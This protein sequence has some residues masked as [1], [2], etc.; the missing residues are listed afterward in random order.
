M[1]KNKICT[2]QVSLFVAFVFLF[3]QIY[4]PA[5]SDT[6]QDC[7][8]VSS[9]FNLLRAQVEGVCSGIEEPGIPPDRHEEY[10]FPFIVQCIGNILITEKEEKENL[11]VEKIQNYLNEMLLSR[12]SANELSRYDL[13]KVSR[14]CNVIKIELKDGS[15]FYRFYLKGDAVGPE[16]G[17]IENTR[18]MEISG[19][20][21]RVPVTAVAQKISYTGPR[22]I[23]SGNWTSGQHDKLNEMIKELIGTEKDVTARYARGIARVKSDIAESI[24]NFFTN[25]DPRYLGKIEETIKRTNIK[26]DTASIVT[27]LKE[28]LTDPKFKCYF[29]LPKSGDDEFRFVYRGENRKPLI[30]HAQAHFGHNKTRGPG[31]EQNIYISSAYYDGLSESDRIALIIHEMVHLIFGDGNDAHILGDLIAGGVSLSYDKSKYDLAA[32]KRDVSEYIRLKDELISHVLADDREQAEKARNEWIGINEDIGKRGVSKRTLTAFILEDIA[33]KL[34]PAF[35]ELAELISGA[36]SGDMDEIFEKNNIGPALRMIISES[37]KTIPRY[38]ARGD[39]MYLTE[40]ISATAEKMAIEIFCGANEAFPPFMDK[41]IDDVADEVAGALYTDGAAKDTWVKNMKRDISLFNI[42]NYITPDLFSAGSFANKKKKDYLTGTLLQLNEIFNKGAAFY[43]PEIK[44][45]FVRNSWNICRLRGILTHELVHYLADMGQL[46]ADPGCEYTTY[47]IGLCADIMHTGAGGVKE[48]EDNLDIAGEGYLPGA[49]L[50]YEKGKEISASGRSAYILKPSRDAK[51][52]EYFSIDLL[53]VEAL[54]VYEANGISGDQLRRYLASRNKKLTTPFETEQFHWDRYFAQEACGFIM[55][56]ILMSEYEKAG[57]HPLTQLRDYFEELDKVMGPPNEQDEIWIEKDLIPEMETLGRQLFGKKVTLESSSTT[58]RLGFWWCESDRF[59]ANIKYWPFTIIPKDKD[60]K[61]RAKPRKEA[62]ERA[63]GN[64]L[65]ALYRAHNTNDPEFGE[66]HKE[67]F[68]RPEF[69]VLW[70]TLLIPRAVYV[71]LPLTQRKTD[72]AGA[73]MYKDVPDIIQKVFDARYNFGNLEIEKALFNAYPLHMRYLDSILYRWSQYDRKKHADTLPDDPRLEK[74]GV[75][76]EAARKSFD[77]WM[78]LMFF[79]QEHTEY[80]DIYNVMMAQIWPVYKELFEKDLEI[81]KNR[82]LYEMLKDKEGLKD[83]FEDFDPSNLTAEQEELLEDIFKDLPQE[84]KDMLAENSEDMMNGS[85]LGGQ[86][87]QAGGADSSGEPGPGGKGQSGQSS[88]GGSGRKGDSQGDNKGSAAGKASGSSPA[89]A[90]EEGEGTQGTAALAGKAGKMKRADISGD[91]NEI[92]K[93]LNS[94][95]ETIKGIGRS[96]DNIGKGAGEIKE[97]TR[98]GRKRSGQIEN[99]K[100]DEMSEKGKVL[101]DSA[102]ELRKKGEGLS[103]KTGEIRKDSFEAGEEMPLSG[104]D[105]GVKKGAVS[106]E[107]DAKGINEDIKKLQE[108]V[109]KLKKEIDRLKK[110]NDTTRDPAQISELVD[111]IKDTAS[112]A[113]K[114]VRDVGKGVKGAAGTVEE[115]RK[116]VSKLARAVEE[117]NKEIDKGLGDKLDKLGKEVGSGGEKDKDE[118]SG[119]L[120][121]SGTQPRDTGGGAEKGSSPRKGTDKSDNNAKRREKG[122]EPTQ[123][124]PEDLKELTLPKGSEASSLRDIVDSTKSREEYEGVDKYS[125]RTFEAEVNPE[126]A[127][128]LEEEMLLEE[129]RRM[130]LSKE[131]RE[132]YISW[133]S[134]LESNML[135][136]MRKMIRAFTVPAEDTE[137]ESKKWS[138]ILKKPMRALTGGDPYVVRKETRPRPAQFVFLI[139]ISGSMSG[140][141]NLYARLTV[142]AFLLVILEINKELKSRSLP[143]IEFQVGRFNETAKPLIDENVFEE[144]GEDR[145]PRLIYDVLKA[146][147]ANG[148]TD[149]INALGGFITRLK[150]KPK[151]VGAENEPRKVLFHIGDGDVNYGEKE[152]MRKVIA[153]AEEDAARKVDV[154][155]VSTGDDEARDHV[156]QAFG[157]NRSILPVEPDLS[158]LPE[159]CLRRFAESLAP[160]NYDFPWQSVLAR[161]LML[162]TAPASLAHMAGH[163]LSNIYLSAV[164]K[165]GAVRERETGYRHFRYETVNGKDYLVWRRAD[166]KGKTHELRWQRGAGGKNVPA[167][168]TVDDNYNEEMMLKIIRSMYLEGVEYTSYSEDGKYYLRQQ[169]KNRLVLMEKVKM[170]DGGTEWVEKKEFTI[171]RNAPANTEEGGYKKFSEE[172]VNW[173]FDGM[174]NLYIDTGEG[175][176]AGVICGKSFSEYSRVEYDAE[177]NGYRVFDGENARV[178]FVRKN[179]KDVFDIVYDLSIEKFAKAEDW[180]GKIVRLIGETGLG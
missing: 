113:A 42:R 77:G 136:D 82:K 52:R 4:Y 123:D 128:M 70:E 140:M 102:D 124:T 97:A 29:L 145:I 74:G 172:G 142:M 78:K 50:L 160:P 103:K 16:E 32:V 129:C 154:F 67:M 146:L 168:I 108:K 126:W 149:Q 73:K 104:M 120:E 132:E 34:G 53:V 72:D 79:I 153:F 14:A 112:A 13:G 116:D 44:K 155:G 141:R 26:T 98:E 54:K 3:N 177:N 119:A 58:D 9:Q 45:I 96:A 92:E 110:F 60:Q 107:E 150:E 5:F 163:L 17:R 6:K 85:S 7:L 131:E 63:I 87:G 89:D 24:D 75:V 1:K 20:A 48:R 122:Q 88:S 76:D 180:D 56:G 39:E 143:L 66:G 41:L 133:L 38:A 174:S 93:M 100:L 114:A 28:L 101:K 18:E 134:G 8:G 159:L 152:S 178:V 157:E 64:L 127:K 139:D 61:D 33:E 84:V 57:V 22:N 164:T 27:S 23:A 10:V 137:P 83:L 68:A 130:G 135:D 65:L 47:A 30:L 35:C 165:D 55:A 162:F 37:A 51:S 46:K 40:I 21:G 71:S 111:A 15:G 171:S 166:A 59:H 158:D 99:S 95:E 121:G 115:L 90:G 118:P 169:D 62:K 2:K 125:G 156:L 151:P 36:V 176:W 179:G 94:V 147:E 167:K 138:G 106:L 80:E 49:K 148:S 12:F 173:R 11:R 175:K 86:N 161:M 43:D 170:P 25:V 19:R 105:K 144:K 109:N 69:S 81:E 91:I 31:A 117:L